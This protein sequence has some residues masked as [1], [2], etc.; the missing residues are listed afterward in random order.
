MKKVI[1]TKVEGRDGD[2]SLVVRHFRSKPEA[3]HLGR[4]LKQT[5]Y[6]EI[7]VTT[8]SPYN[9]RNIAGFADAQD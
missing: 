8:K 9:L 4:T 6:S 3:V 7:T 5:L 1:L 2:G